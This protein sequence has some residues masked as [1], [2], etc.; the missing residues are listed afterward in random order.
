MD[1]SERIAV[2]EQEISQLQERFRQYGAEHQRQLGIAFGYSAAVL[3][4]IESHHN[5]DFLFPALAHAYQQADAYANGEAQTDEFPQGLQVANEQISASL[6]ILL[7]R[8]GTT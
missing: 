8:P 7:K 4:L 6:D 3:A 1:D 2:L 5:Y